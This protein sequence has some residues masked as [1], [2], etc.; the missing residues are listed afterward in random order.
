MASLSPA[1]NE[2]V[3]EDFLKD[4][5]LAVVDCDLPIIPNT[6]RVPIRR[7]K[8]NELVKVGEAIR[9]TPDLSNTTGFFICRLNKLS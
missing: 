5:H 8:D 3:I 4:E 7:Q 2:H 6:L 9:F 1:Q